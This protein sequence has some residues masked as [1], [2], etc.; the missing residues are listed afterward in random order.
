MQQIAEMLDYLIAE[1]QHDVLGVS[2]TALQEIF[3]QIESTVLDVF[4]QSRRDC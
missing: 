1:N 4:Y 3:D 2:P